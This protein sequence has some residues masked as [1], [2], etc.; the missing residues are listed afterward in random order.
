MNRRIPLLV[1]GAGPFGLAIAAHA[2]R[3]GIETVIVGRPMSFWQA[4]MPKG[5]FLR[6]AADWHFD[7][8]DEDTIE[9]YFRT[10][11]I[12]AAE[13]TPLS[14]DFYL[15]YCAW[16]S[17][18]KAIEPVPVQVHSLDGVHDVSPFFEATT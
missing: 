8:F 16:F 11:N 17:R 18:Q 15:G 3:R 13:V 5:M 7:P 6:S 14:L 1:I 2:R 9:H 12:G 4:N 10:K